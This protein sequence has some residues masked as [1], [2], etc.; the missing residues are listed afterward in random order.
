MSSLPLAHFAHAVNRHSPVIFPLI[1]SALIVLCSVKLSRIP[2][3]Q[4]KTPKGV[5]WV[6]RN[7]DEAF[8]G[9]RVFF[10]ALR[11]TRSWLADGYEK[12]RIS[13]VAC[14]NE[15][16]PNEAIVVHEARQTIYSA[17]HLWEI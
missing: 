2:R 9:T 12:V 16:P 17:N 4:R 8:A 10:S 14:A 5:P 6:G 15:F 1:I 13:L 3:G 11:A 7:P